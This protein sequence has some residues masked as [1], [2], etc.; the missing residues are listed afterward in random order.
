MTCFKFTILCICIKLCSSY[1]QIALITSVIMALDL[2]PLISSVWISKNMHKEKNL[3][4]TLINFLPN[5]WS[6]CLVYISVSS[7][8]TLVILCS[9]CISSHLKWHLLITRIF[10]VKIWHKFIFTEANQTL[11]STPHT[12][13]ATMWYGLL[14]QAKYNLTFHSSFANEDDIYCRT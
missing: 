5:F 3:V 6:Y 12:L 10:A 4:C 1:I 2:N 7:D 9:I 14:F 13:I 11:I 8:S